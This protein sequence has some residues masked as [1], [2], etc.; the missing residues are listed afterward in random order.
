MMSAFVPM[1][2]DCKSSYRQTKAGLAVNEN[3]R[4]QCQDCKR[5]YVEE[6][7]RFRY[8][9]A[10]RTRAV[11][12]HHRGQPNR[13]IARTLSV[14]HQTFANWVKR[15]EGSGPSIPGITH[16]AHAP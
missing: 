5:Y 9:S 15:D 1:C 14:N 13:A 11:E 3:Q 7:R 2:P 4:F 16:S 8:L 10:M 6:N 12:L